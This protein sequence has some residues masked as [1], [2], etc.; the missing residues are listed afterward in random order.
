MSSATVV[1]CNLGSVKG[2][3]FVGFCLPQLAWQEKVGTGRSQ[4][5]R[6][7][8]TSPASSIRRKDPRPVAQ[9]PLGWEGSLRSILFFATD[10]GVA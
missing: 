5:A 10:Q 4:P 8:T 7:S 2:S 9:V 1:I 6:K 3:T